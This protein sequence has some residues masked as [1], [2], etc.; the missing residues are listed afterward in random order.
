MYFLDFEAK[1][2]FNIT[3]SHRI[4]QNKIKSICD[5]CIDCSVINGCVGTCRNECIGMQKKI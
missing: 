3:N 1:T 5:N 2:T 4:K